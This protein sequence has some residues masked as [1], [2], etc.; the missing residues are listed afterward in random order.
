MVVTCPPETLIN[1]QY[2]KYGRSVPSSV[3][4][5]APSTE[6]APE[7]AFS[8]QNSDLVEDTNCIAVRSLECNCQKEPLNSPSNYSLSQYNEPESPDID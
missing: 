2:A 5:S 1:I 7:G 6:P 8:E 4:C 3:M